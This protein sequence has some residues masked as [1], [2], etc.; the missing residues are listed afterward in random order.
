MAGHVL[1]QMCYIWLRAYLILDECF[2]GLDGIKDLSYP[3]Q[4]ELGRELFTLCQFLKLDLI[5]ISDAKILG[6]HFYKHRQR[7]S[8]LDFDQMR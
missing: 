5:H 1:E 6:E 2:V 7:S 3:L 8:V 4:V